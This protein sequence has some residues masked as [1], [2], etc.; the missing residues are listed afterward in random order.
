MD[1]F[2]HYLRRDLQD[3][4]SH[5]ACI[6]ITRRLLSAMNFM[7]VSIRREAMLTAYRTSDSSMEQTGHV[8]TMTSQSPGMWWVRQDRPERLER[9][10][11]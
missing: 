5:H 7:D 9:H 10:Q 2:S 6:R 1:D 4:L 8:G 3:L 11:G